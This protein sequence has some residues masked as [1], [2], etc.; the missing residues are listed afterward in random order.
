MRS[1]PR[2]YY[3]DRLLLVCAAATTLVNLTGGWRER[4]P[5]F[6]IFYESSSLFV[7]GADPY[8]DL[9]LRGV[10]PNTNIPSIVVLLSPLTRLPFTWAAVVWLL[11]GFVAFFA[12]IRMLAPNV[13]PT[14]PRTLLFVA[15]STETAAM[16]IRQG[17]IAFFVMALFSYA[18]VADLRGHAMRSGLAIGATIA[19]KPF[20]GL[21]APYLLWRRDGRALL[22]LLAGFASFWSVGLASGPAIVRSWVE[23]LA[24]INWQAHPTNVS[25]RGMAAR[26]FSNPP[27]RPYLLTTTP[28][29]ASVRLEAV[30][31]MVAAASIA[32]VT[33]RSIVRS[34]DRAHAWAI[35]SVA[36]LLLSPLAEVHYA[37]VG[38]GPLALTFIRSRRWTAAWLVGI[39]MSIPFG[40]VQMLGRGPLGTFSF[41]STY[42]WAALALWGTLAFGHV[43][44]DR[45]PAVGVYRCSH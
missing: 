39:A 1:F 11:L 25:L 32:F 17:Q 15:L 22:G 10:G 28:L 26:W 45:Q 8:S 16:T 2:E 4:F 40:I 19:L 24:G 7:A 44:Q 41:G 43:N 5:D 38:L 23:S 3:V 6:A 13:V 37:F 12:A 31:W 29:V 33:A 42:G 18:W 30:F 36:A 9:Y 14:A 34:R 21:L 35:L 27:Q 20:Y